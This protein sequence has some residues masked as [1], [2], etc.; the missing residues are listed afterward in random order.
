MSEVQAVHSKLSMSARARWSRCA[1]SVPWSDGLPDDSG[2]AAEEGVIAHKVAE[3]YV[4]HRFGLEMPDEWRGLP[5]P[6]DY[7]PPTGL[8]LKG[9]PASQWNAK[10]RNHGRDYAEFIA[11]LVSAYTDARIVLERR[12]DVQG[13]QPPLFGTADC[14]IWIPSRAILIGVDYKYG[15]GEVDVGT[16]E[17]PNEQVAG[18]LVAAAETFGLQPKQLGLAIYQPRRIHGE[19]GQVLVLDGAWVPQEHAKLLAEARA[20]EA[21]YAAPD[22]TSPVPGA[23]CRYCKAAKALRC[24]A[25]QKAGK[26]ALQAHVKPTLVHDLADAEL[27]ALW[28]VRAAFKNFWEDVEAR[29][30]KLADTGAAGLVVKVAK[31][32][33]MWAD[34]QAAVTT[35]LALGRTDLLSPAAIGEA[36]AA[37]PA[38]LHSQLVGTA[39]GA[40][41]ILATESADPLTVA[42]VFNRYAQVTP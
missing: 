31:G 29:I 25:V 27:I 33:R 5:V 23:H 19:P 9:Q 38:E 28:A 14:L 6:M 26:M 12:V 15:F 42:A 32:R 34:P 13:T 11:G 22:S 40:K 3:F 24:T 21:A 37:I 4:R 2:P 18:Y 30:A 20:V 39:N 36:L 16:P 8:D 35:L 17:A 41:T 7:A 10:M 1:V